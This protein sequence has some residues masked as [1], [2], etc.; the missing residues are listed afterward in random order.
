MRKLFIFLIVLSLTDIA[1]AQ[2]ARNIKLRFTTPL[3]L[4]RWT[5]VD[6]FNTVDNWELSSSTTSEKTGQGIPVYFRK[7]EPGVNFLSVSG[8]QRFFTDAYKNNPSCLGIKVVFPEMSSAI[9]TLSPKENY[10]IDGRCKKLAFWLLGRGRNVDFGIIIKDYLGRYYYLDVTKL[11]FIGWKY[12]KIDIP[13]YIPQSFDIYPQRMT[14]E[15]AGF[16]VINHPTQ[17]AD[18][19]YKPFYLYIDQLDAMV[20]R[21]TKQYPGI[22]IRDDWWKIDLEENVLCM[23]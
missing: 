21:F 23:L 10:K 11:N 12:F 14:I 3:D 2:L 1:N 18:T 7:V 22:E 13:I 15:I 8:E 5:V 9:V 17:Y 6:D 20:D 16:Y 19:L 4:Q